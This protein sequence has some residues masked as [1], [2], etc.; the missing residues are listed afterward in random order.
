[1]LDLL[2]SEF[3]DSFTATP[4][5]VAFI[6]LTAAMVL[7]GL[8]GWERERHEKSA[9]L[10]THIMIALAACLFTLIAFDLM[11]LPR[12]DEDILRTDPLRLIEAVTSGVA[13]LAAGSIITQGVKVK[14]LTTGAG[15][16]LAGAIGLTCGTGNIPLA[17]L[18]T[19]L[20]L[21]VLWLL[22][23]LI[24]QGEAPDERSDPPP[25]RRE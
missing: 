20:A 5:A 16:W 2:R 4:F 3:L 19:T 21:I 23:R 11:E 6:R 10:R 9:G 12:N 22:H 17:A 15:M 18:A 8:I 14:G 1:M 7:G 13:F 24:G 25:P